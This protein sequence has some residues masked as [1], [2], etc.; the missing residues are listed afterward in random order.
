MVAQQV[1]LI[2]APEMTLSRT[3]ASDSWQGVGGECGKE[4]QYMYR[5]ES[6]CIRTVSMA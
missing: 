3:I 6:S 5:I 2:V 1:P 4:Q